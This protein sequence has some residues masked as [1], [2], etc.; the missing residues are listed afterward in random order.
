M[1]TVKE[2]HRKVLSRMSTQKQSVKSHSGRNTR[3]S[4]KSTGE[5][6]SNSC[7]QEIPSQEV[8]ATPKTH[9]AGKK[10]STPA[11]SKIPISSPQCDNKKK[12]KNNQDGQKNK[13]LGKGEDIRDFLAPQ[14]LNSNS[15]KEMAECSEVESD[16]TIVMEGT[17]P[18]GTKGY[19]SPDQ[20]STVASQ[21]SFHSVHSKP[22]DEKCNPNFSQEKIDNTQQSDTSEQDAIDN[23]PKDTVGSTI[24][25]KQTMDGIKEMNQREQPVNTQTAR[26]M[27]STEK[28]ENPIIDVKELEKAE[29]SNAMVVNM[30]QQL[31]SS[32]NSMKQDLSSEIQN[33]RSEKEG[34]SDRIDAIQVTQKSQGDDIRQLKK[35]NKHYKKQVSKLADAVAFQR[36]VITELCN[37]TD[38]HELD[39]YKPNLIIQGLP[40]KKEENCMTEVKEFFKEKLNLVHDIQIKYAYRIGNGKHRPIK[41]SLVHQTDKGVIYSHAKNLKG[42][43]NRNGKGYKIDDDLPPKLREQKNKSRHFMWKNKKTTAEKIEMSVKKGKLMVNGKLYE[44]KIKEPS[45]HLLCRLKE[46]EVQE[47]LKLDVRKGQEEILDG[48]MFVGYVADVQSYDDVNAAYE[49]VR[50]HNLSA[51]HIVAACIIP[52]DNVLEC[53]DFCDSGEHGAGQ[54]LLNY[55][56]ESDLE[57][58]AIFV[59]RYYEGKH[60]GPKRFE[61][62]VNAAKSAINHKP[63]NTT[64]NNYQFSWGSR[65][66][67]K[68]R[69]GCAAGSRPLRTMSEAGS[70]ASVDTTHSSEQVP[71]ID[72][73]KNSVPES[74]RSWAGLCTTPP[75]ERGAS[76]PLD[77]TTGKKSRMSALPT[78]LPV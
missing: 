17:P 76:S 20:Q 69:G 23:R 12:S 37:K 4:A 73:D 11:K 39:K 48:S 72:F 6:N 36:H 78:G 45:D 47:L 33:L 54:K 52:G 38:V 5:E 51:R 35:E 66:R 63:F 19:C 28:I 9:K 27:N 64:T 3:N 42:K 57:N 65:G 41:V 67:M 21:Q 46:D 29:I 61:L 50:Y 53:A 13:G 44:S 49:W 32:M 71:E 75:L 18:T 74:I 1:Q 24:N 55:M 14:C 2:E 7:M 60:I 30:F 40:E 31:M 10:P 62:I 58:R 22:P 26:I 70:E 77:G 43:T 16:S 15:L 8:T 59:A 68:G 34:N 25:K 56:E